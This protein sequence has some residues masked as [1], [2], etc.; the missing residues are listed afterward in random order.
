MADNQQIDQM[1]AYVCGHSPVDVNK[2]S[3]E[4]KKLIQDVRDIIE[5]ARLMVTEENADGL[6][7]PTWNVPNTIQTRSS[8]FLLIKR[9]RTVGKHLRTL[10]SLVLTNAEVRKL[11]GD[12]S[13]IG[14]DILARGAVHTAKGTRPDQE[15]LQNVDRSAPKDTFITEAGRQASPYETSVLEA[16]VPD[17]D[18]RRKHV[19]RRRGAMNGGADAAKQAVDTTRAQVRNNV[20]A[21]ETDEEKTEVAKAGFKDK[22]MGFRDNL[23]IVS[24]KWTK[25][26]R[27]TKQCRDQFIFRGKKKRDDYQHYIRWLLGFYENYASHGKH[28]PSKGQESHQALAEDPALNT[29]L[30]QLRTLLERFAN[31]QS[32][33]VVIDAANALYAGAQNEE[34]LR[35]W[36][37]SVDTYIRRVLLEPGFVLKPECNN[38]ANRVRHSGRRLHEGKYN[39]HFANLFD[40]IGSWF[41]AMGEDPLNSRGQLEVGAS[42]VGRSQ[43]G[44]VPQLIDQV[45]YVPI[46]RIEYT[47]DALDLVLENTASSEPLPE[48]R[49]ERCRRQD[50]ADEQSARQTNSTYGDVQSLGPPANVQD[51][52]C[53]TWGQQIRGGEGIADDV[54]GAGQISPVLPF[55]ELFTHIERP[56]HV[57]SSNLL[58]SSPHQH[59]SGTISTHLDELANCTR[60]LD[61]SKSV[62]DHEDLAGYNLHHHLSVS[63]ILAISSR[64]AFS[65]P[66]KQLHEA[67]ATTE[68]R[69]NFGF[70]SPSLPTTVSSL[71]LSRPPPSAPTKLTMTSTT[72]EGQLD[73]SKARRS[74]AL[75]QGCR[76][77]PFAQTIHAKPERQRLIKTIRDLGRDT[78]GWTWQV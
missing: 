29:A 16:R 7:T 77:L 45:D 15:R 44:I 61:G 3:P 65:S 51:N 60:E 59:A 69:T 55:F 76:N 33:Q 24:G 39:T 63:S 64:Q 30:F 70:A 42:A 74:L 14:H 73:E 71:S 50:D 49:L 26:S 62:E 53:E 41:R 66:V 1:L 48:H 27:M 32:L 46:P 13:I 57:Q 43:E 36:F 8:P 21:A 34:E 35:D 18:W 25:I 20:D 47:D 78:L 38:E 72:H 11:L 6:A 52:V 5:T 54:D 28:V 56:H 68:S 75:R 67:T 17:Q 40:T 22:I 12:F 37:H 4:G 19:R 58:S 31:G 23:S 10:L 2:L 9:R